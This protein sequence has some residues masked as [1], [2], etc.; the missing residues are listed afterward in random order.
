MEEKEIHD[1]LSSIRNL[2]E[3]SSKFI[4][5]SG[6]SGV[7]A[8]V[9][10][11]IGA[12]VAYKMVYTNGSFFAYR[13]YVFS[14]DTYDANLLFTL[15]LVAVAVLIMSITTCLLLTIRKAR[16]KSQ[17]VWG[18]TSRA[19]LFNM[20]M[21]LLS[22][23]ILMAIFIVRGYFGIVAPASLIFYGLALISAG[24][25]T[26][27]D[28]K[29]LGVLQIVLGLL[30]ACLPGYGLLFWG[31]GFGVLHIIYGSIMYFKYDG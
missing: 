1:E 24:N 3:R 22:G 21:P 4:S 12:V 25:F 28:V 2:M 27:G 8:G 17:Q 31:L 6:L 19:F 29:Y 10:A 14:G 23:G 18:K 16:K 7:L 5:L 30:A 15:I 11:L 26:F 13:E 20:A 9:Y